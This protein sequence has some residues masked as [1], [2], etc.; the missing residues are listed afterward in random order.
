MQRLI[1]FN[2]GIGTGKD[3]AANFLRGWTH[4]SFAYELKKMAIATDPYV[5]MNNGEFIR[6]A[7]LV[8]RVGLEKAKEHDDVRRYFQRLGTEG[9]RET[10]GQDC[11]V[12]LA[13][14]KTPEDRSCVFTDGRFENE[15]LWIRKAGGI[16]VNILGP[17]RRRK[18]T[19]AAQHVSEKPLPDHLFHYRL[20]NTGTLEQ[21]KK[22]MVTI[23]RS[24]TPKVLTTLGEP[25]EQH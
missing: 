9:C 2:G 10:F 12:R 25:I 20:Y 3:T 16:T 8:V 13:S 21:L 18:T 15:L 6:L 14:S 5:R 7:E 22:H 19:E 17:N 23:A 24:K 11:W 1:C 4:G